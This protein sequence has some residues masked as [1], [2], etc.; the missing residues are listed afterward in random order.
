MNAPT[1]QH[2][3]EAGLGLGLVLRVG[4][5]IEVDPTLH[6]TPVNIGA[7]H[8]QDPTLMR[9]STLFEMLFSRLKSWELVT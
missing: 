9:N 4:W 1:W 5:S 3:S 8:N 6:T 2:F 7:S